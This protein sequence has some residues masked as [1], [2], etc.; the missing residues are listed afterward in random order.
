MNQDS[1]TELLVSHL[2]CF[3]KHVLVDCFG[4]IGESSSTV[5]HICMFCQRA[6]KCSLSDQVRPRWEAPCSSYFHCPSMWWN[7]PTV[8]YIPCHYSHFHLWQFSEEAFAESNMANPYKPSIR[9]RWEM[10][11]KNTFKKRIRPVASL[12]LKLNLTCGTYGQ[13]YTLTFSG[14]R[15]PLHPDPICNK[16]NCRSSKV[17]FYSNLLRGRTKPRRWSTRC[18]TGTS[19]KILSTGCTI[20]L[21]ERQP[22]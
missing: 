7:P 21:T 12:S 8:P 6:M 15:Q 3:Q 18:L 1:A 9:R 14:Q 2:K 11:D 20:S 16:N 13:L 22:D 4:G 5:C 19:L 17:T 10:Y